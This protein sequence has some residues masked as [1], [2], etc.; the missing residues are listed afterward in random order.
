MQLEGREPLVEFLV[1]VLGIRVGRGGVYLLSHLH[2]IFDGF[3]PSRTVAGA[4]TF[5]PSWVLDTVLA[6][7]SSEYP[8]RTLQRQ[9]D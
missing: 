3:L 5:S 2:R 4:P 7:S 9:Y 1:H 6:K 8:V